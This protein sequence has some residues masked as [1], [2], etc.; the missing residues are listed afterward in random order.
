MTAIRMNLYITKGCEVNEIYDN[1]GEAFL[2]SKAKSLYDLIVFQG[3]AILSEI[4]ATTPSNCVSIVLL[5]DS[6]DSLS[7]VQIAQKLSKSHQLIS[8]RINKLDKLGLIHRHLNDNDKR[9]KVIS[10]TQEGKDDVLK[11]EQA[12]EIADQH[13]QELY[14]KLNINIGQAIEMMEDSLKS[15]PLK[16]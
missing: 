5:L 7:T 9:A 14:R 2:A 4:G 6:Y 15:S 3:A 16:T 10:L 1:Y 8:Q 13:F 12:C 11:V